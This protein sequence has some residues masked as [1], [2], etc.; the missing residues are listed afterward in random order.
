MRDCWLSSQSSGV[1][2][3]LADRPQFQQRAKRGGRGRGVELPRGG[4]LGGG[5]DDAGEDHRQ[6]QR[7]QAGGRLTGGQQ[8]IEADLAS[9]AQHRGDV[10]VRQAA[11]HRQPLGGAAQ[12]LVAQHPAQPLDLGERPVRQIGQGSAL[13]LAVLSV[14]FPQQVGRR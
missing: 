4:Q 7:G 9:D 5:I 14:A 12:H 1:E 10:S 2:F 11:Q 6:D 3:L 13:D 8:A